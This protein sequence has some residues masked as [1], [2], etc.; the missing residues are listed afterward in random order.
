[1]K[2]KGTLFYIISACGYAIILMLII[3]IFK[4]YNLFDISRL[5]IMDIIIESILSGFIFFF[6]NK[7]IISRRLKRKENIQVK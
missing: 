7:F 1:M 6:I 5:T 2:D 4:Y 3:L